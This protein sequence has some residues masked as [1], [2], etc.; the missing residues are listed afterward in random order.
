MIDAQK[1]TYG[2]GLD[3]E[4]L[5]PY[6]WAV[7]SHY[8]STGLGFYNYPYAF[9]LLF[10]LGL[11]ARAREEGPAFAG[12]YRELLRRT[13]LASAADVARAAGFDI[14]GDAFWQKGLALIAG[15][16]G[17]FEKLAAKSKYP[18]SY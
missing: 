11:Y 14:E 7:K 8:Y 18:F 12:T 9:G 6:M 17:D 2:D 15:R 16:I 5:H 3:P 13:G 4:L 10:S 1:K